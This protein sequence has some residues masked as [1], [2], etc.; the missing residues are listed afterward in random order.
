VV[1]KHLIAQGARQA[2][3]RFTIL[4]GVSSPPQGGGGHFGHRNAPTQPTPFAFRMAKHFH[5][6]QKAIR[7]VLHFTKFPNFA[8]ETN[9][10]ESDMEKAKQ[11]LKAYFGYDEFR[12]LQ[13]EIIEE[14]LA[15]RDTVVLMPTGGG[16]SICFQ[17]PAI[18]LDGL[19]IVVSPLIALMKDQ[20]ESLKSNGVRAEFINSSSQSSEN[21]RVEQLAMSGQLDLLYVSPEKVLSPDFF[22][23][24]PELKIALFAI[25]EAHCISQWGHDFRPEYVQ[26]RVLKERFPLVPVIALTATAD[27]LTRKDI[28]QHLQLVQPKVFVASFD[29]PN[30]SLK[31]VNGK[32]RAREIVR[33][34]K[35]RPGQ[36]GIIYCL[37][38]KTTEEVSAK[39]VDAGIRAAFYHAKLSSQDRSDV[40]EKFL[41]DDLDVI[42]ATIAFGMGIDKSNVRWVVHY[43]L[44]KNIEGYY[45][46]IGRAG[47]DGLPSET[48][49]FFSY[50]D[51]SL[52]QNFVDQSG[53]K[54][55]LQTKLDRMQ[56]YAN[57]KT[58]RRQFLLSY[59][60]EQTDGFCGNCDNCKSPAK[61]IDATII[62]QKALSAVLRAN[63][64]VG[65]N[66]LID[67]LRGSNN[68][69]LKAKGYHLIKTWGAGSDISKGD[70][71]ELILQMLNTGIFEMAYDE[72]NALKVTPTGNAVLFEGRKVLLSHTP[73]QQQKVKVLSPVPREKVATFSEALFERLRKVRK[74][75][76]DAEGVPPYVIFHDRTLRIMAEEHPTSELSMRQ[77]SGMSERKFQLYG[78]DFMDTILR[79]V[80]ERRQPATRR[81]T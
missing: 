9:C 72:G 65:L 34:V 18:V 5:K 36:S 56:Q 50:G 19:C 79:F 24:L 69:E 10:R 61:T 37:S 4:E 20:V 68:A 25:D 81:A 66:M 38:R 26:M 31:V 60:G 78:A 39:L 67:I 74:N 47:R 6:R 14:V 54:D 27:K 45:Q 33:W 8:L 35:D 46:E 11:A 28:E 23:I 15:G 58:C 55:I 76:A 48:Q 51:V 22:G 7:S 52:L 57:A 44:P 32:E 59:F 30:L 53:Q 21:Q 16:K 40:Q 64:K 63:E 73:V 71:I 80:Q 49:L 3:Q 70:W 62:T 41:R 29:R 43:N 12:P 77:V 42:C 75:I 17:I 1:V 2:I 13:A